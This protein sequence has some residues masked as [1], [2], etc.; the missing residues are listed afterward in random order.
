MERLAALSQNSDRQQLKGG[1]PPAARELCRFVDQYLADHLEIEEELHVSL[2]L[3]GSPL[4][5]VDDKTC[6]QREETFHFAVTSSDSDIS[7]RLE[8]AALECLHMNCPMY[9]EDEV[10]KL[11]IKSNLRDGVFFSLVDSKMAF[12]YHFLSHMR[13][14]EHTLHS[15]RVLHCLRGVKG[16]AKLYGI[17]LSQR[18]RRL[19]SILVEVPTR[20]PIFELMDQAK[21]AGNPVS[22]KQ[23]EIWCR[24]LTKTISEVHSRG[25]VV[26]TTGYGSVAID[27][28]GDAKLWQF[29][30]V[31][32]SPLTRYFKGIIPPIPPEN[33]MGHLSPEQDIS[34][35]ILPQIDVYYLGLF[36][37]LVAGYYC[38]P[39]VGSQ[40]VLHSCTN[41]PCS[42]IHTEAIALPDLGDDVPEYFKRIVAACRQEDPMDR[43]PA[44]AVLE[45]FPR[46][47]YGMI[48]AVP[49]TAQPCP[50]HVK[51]HGTDDIHV[52]G[53]LR[54]DKSACGLVDADAIWYSYGNSCDSCGK[55]L[56]D[57]YFRCGLY[58]DH[59]YDLCS[60]CVGNGSHCMDSSHFLVEC[61]GVST[62]VA[63]PK[64][65]YSSPREHGLRDVVR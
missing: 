61:R 14:V 42:T 37:W 8:K 15:L 28:N 21:R 12:D 60:R 9:L 52:A 62:E 22:W 23:R 24:Q 43:P 30:F 65:Y 32:H 1:Y 36:F 44:W 46:D 57:P 41:N 54:V 45:M 27:D 11:P 19:K 39:W 5:V 6:R 53:D 49:S 7:R 33:S 2:H 3:Q 29:S 47:D 63:P 4:S 51:E 50:R 31:L 17:V 38:N 64:T 34:I 59:N 48:S 55:T 25:F 56:T 35:N 58:K 10:V 26:G 40:C 18:T 13:Q 20:G 16:V